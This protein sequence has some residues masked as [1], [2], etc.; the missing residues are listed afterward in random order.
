MKFDVS[1]LK[2]VLQQIT[3]MRNL[4]IFGTISSMHIFVG[5]TLQAAGRKDQNVNFLKGRIVKSLLTA[6]VNYHRTAVSECKL[7]AGK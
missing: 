7:D 5:T 1:V 3:G 2:N 4:L 6:G